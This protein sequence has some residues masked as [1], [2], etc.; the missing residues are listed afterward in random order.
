MSS[1][2]GPGQSSKLPYLQ[3]LV[4]LKH[5]SLKPGTHILRPK[6]IWT[7]LQ[8]EI[9]D[10]HAILLHAVSSGFKPQCAQICLQR[11]RKLG[12]DGYPHLLAL[13]MDGYPHLLVLQTRV[14][15]VAV[16]SQPPARFC[17]SREL[18]CK[19]LGQLYFLSEQVVNRYVQ[20]ARIQRPGWIPTF[21]L[22]QWMDTHISHLMGSVLRLSMQRESQVPQHANCLGAALFPL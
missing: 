13:Q 14:G 2:L 18:A 8:R 22:Q 5:A 12:P 4:H 3:D 19:L 7:S 16:A 20:R 9:P 1:E 15:I 10:L 6:R 17:G 11:A 21:A